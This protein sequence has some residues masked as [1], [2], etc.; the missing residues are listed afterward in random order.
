M[1]MIKRKKLMSKTLIV[2][3]SR[4]N[5][6]G[7]RRRG[8]GPLPWR[9]A[10]R[11]NQRGGRRRR[12]GRWPRRSRQGRRRHSSGRPKRLCAHRRGCRNQRGGRR[13]CSGR[14]SRCSRQ[15]RRRGSRTS[16][17]SPIHDVLQTRVALQT[18]A[19]SMILEDPMT[20]ADMYHI[21]FDPWGLGFLFSVRCA[22]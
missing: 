2:L 11:R 6:V 8:L 22:K 14:W 19:E 18:H 17:R 15:G 3:L 20:H 9:P 10:W 5:P 4:Q 7:Q 13:R 1:L 16:L 21:R 12:S